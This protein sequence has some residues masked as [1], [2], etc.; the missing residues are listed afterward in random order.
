MHIHLCS[1]SEHVHF[2]RQA[3]GTMPGSAS[4]MASRSAFAAGCSASG[5]QYGVVRKAIGRKNWS[6]R[7]QFTQQGVRS[8]LDGPARAL[9]ADAEKDRKSVAAAVGQVP[10]SSRLHIASAA[11]KALRNGQILSDPEV[12]ALLALLWGSIP[13][14]CSK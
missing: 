8:T 12:P 4:T 2:R 5:R 6:A 14:N 10:Q 7:F 11:I 9:R 3:S 1:S 13:E